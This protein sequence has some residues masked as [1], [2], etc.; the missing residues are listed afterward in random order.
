MDTQTSAKLAEMTYEIGKTKG[1]E[2]K[3]NTIFDVNKHLEDEGINYKVV[4]EHTNRNITTYVDKNN[5]K[6]IHISHKGTQFGSTTASKDVVADL[7]LA[8]GQG[9][10]SSHVKKRKKLTERAVKKLN[11]DTLTMSSHSLGGF[12]QNHTIA[13]SKKVR[14]KLLQADTFNAG[15]SPIFD[16]DLGLTK[17]AEKELKNI[18]ITHHRTRN[19]VV[20]VGLKRESAVPFGEVKTYKLRPTKYEK[21]HETSYTKTLKDKKELGRFGFANKSLYAHHLHHFS[22][23]ILDPVKKNINEH[24]RNVKGKNIYSTK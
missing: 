1:K 20:S 2:Q 10:H 4:P 3:L 11:P 6:N 7:M 13:K 8:L 12:S 24:S 19:D 22:N 18:P 14:D 9:G 21:Q 17:E 23:R 16:N 15:S 5:P